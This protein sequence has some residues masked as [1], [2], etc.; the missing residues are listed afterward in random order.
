MNSIQEDQIG[1]SLQVQHEI[2]A[3]NTEE[4]SVFLSLIN[5]KQVYE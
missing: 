2:Q 4:R 1:Q 5:L 3:K